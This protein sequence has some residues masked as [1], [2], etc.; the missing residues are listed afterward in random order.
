[1]EK[2]EAVKSCK[3]FAGFTDDVVAA[4]AEV[5]EE[6]DFEAG[7]DVFVQGGRGASLYVVRSGMVQVVARGR[8]RR[9]TVLGSLV[10]GEHF[11][12]MSLLRAGAHL[13]T[14]RADT[15]TEILEMTQQRFLQ[16]QKERPQAAM[17]LLI[18]L[19]MDFTKLVRENEGFFRDSIAA[20]AAEGN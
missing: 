9:E 7:G 12:G 10:Q 18:A 15:N 17:K 4:C 13:V 1:M 6:K 5:F 11:G 20:R 2:I 16:L 3:L 19:V 14:A 8:D